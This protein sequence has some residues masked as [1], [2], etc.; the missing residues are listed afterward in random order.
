MPSMADAVREADRRGDQ[1][2]KRALSSEFAATLQTVMAALKRDL[3]TSRLP[4]AERDSFVDFVR[5]IVSL[6][7]WHGTDMVAIDPFFLSAGE[8]YSPSAQDPHYVEAGTLF[9]I[10]K[11]ERR[12]RG[13]ETQ[14][15]HF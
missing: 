7:R 9:Y 14:I 2:S 1:Q 15:F 4:P 3:T 13:A 8:Y 5:D 10:G 12:E 6:I 11:L